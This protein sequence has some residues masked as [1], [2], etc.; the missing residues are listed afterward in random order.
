MRCFVNNTFIFVSLLVTVLMNLAY[1][2]CVSAKELGTFGAVYPVVEEDLI[3]K[4]QE[5]IARIDMPRYEREQKDKARKYIL[6][7]KPGSIPGKLPVA[8]KD[9][10]F[11]VDMSYTLDF[12][13]PDGKGGILYP[14]GYTF[15][16]LDYTFLS[17]TI[18][19][20]DGTDRRQI[21]WFK[22]SP[23]HKRLDVTVLLT[24]GTYHVLSKDLKR[25][26]FYASRKIIER[27]NIKALPSVVVQNGNVMNVHEY[28][29]GDASQKISNN[30]K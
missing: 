2:E 5:Y 24:N 14:K 17:K 13:I 22:S 6:N 28:D 27:F 7:Y 4:I 30:S 8:D 20:L 25:P 19:L 3:K 16:P 9:S 11:S 18:V 23:W 15:N 10:V 29:P 21:K 1:A 12:D 26:V